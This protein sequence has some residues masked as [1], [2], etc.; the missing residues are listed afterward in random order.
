MKRKLIYALTCAVIF[1]CT[2]Q[3]DDEIVIDE[4]QE[5]T[6]SEEELVEIEDNS[7]EEIIESFEGNNCVVEME[8]YLSDNS[9][10]PTNIREVPGGDVDLVLPV[11]DDYLFEVIGFK[12]GWFKIKSIWAS[13]GDE[14]VMTD[15]EGWIHRSVVGVGTR[16][17]G[18]Q[19]LSVY[20]EADPDSGISGFIQEETSLKILDVCDDWV[21]VEFNQ[22]GEVIEGWIEKEWVCGNPVTNCC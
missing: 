18:G 17:Y 12:D 16:N 20:K 5:E 3:G 21:K 9:G 8:V 4:V 1:S 13:G 7:E 15:N 10:S 19:E 22:A 2:T 14:F 11:D 6:S